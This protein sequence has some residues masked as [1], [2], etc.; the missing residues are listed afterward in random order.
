VSLHAVA[1]S[2]A[3]DRAATVACAA[4][5]AGLGRISSACACRMGFGCCRVPALAGCQRTRRIAKVVERRSSSGPVAT[6]AV[7]PARGK[8]PAS[9]RIKC[10]SL[11]APPRS[12]AL[13]ACPLTAGPGTPINC[14]AARSSAAQALMHLRARPFSSHIGQNGAAQEATGP[15]LDELRQLVSI[16]QRPSQPLDLYLLPANLKK[17]QQ[18]SLGPHWAH[19]SRLCLYTMAW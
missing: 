4:A 17:G 1:D 7:R 8:A 10:H 14:G 16:T 3:A 18:A 5:G 11:L 6:L 2:L 15:L 12:N 13:P 19:P 9:S